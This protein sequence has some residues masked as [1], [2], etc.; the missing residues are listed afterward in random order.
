M[1]QKTERLAKESTLLGKNYIV[2]IPDERRSCVRI[3]LNDDGHFQERT[4][5]P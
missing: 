5:K 4:E 3:F 2:K 1:F